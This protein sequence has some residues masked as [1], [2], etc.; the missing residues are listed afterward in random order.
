[1]KTFEGDL[2]KFV[3]LVENGENFA[4]SRY[5][6]GELFILQ[7]QKL[8]LAENHCFFKGQKHGGRYPREEQKEFLPEEHSFYRQ[9]LVE[10]FQFKKENYFKGANCRADI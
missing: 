9:K 10:S 2:L 8:V 1:M 3:S 4:Y 6:D 7:N 5:S